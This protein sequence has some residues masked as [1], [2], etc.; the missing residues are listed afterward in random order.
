M[1]FPGPTNMDKKTKLLQTILAGAGAY[2]AIGAV[3][4]FLGLTIFPFYVNNLY[5]PYHDTLVAVAAAIFSAS[6]FVAAKNP[7]RHGTLINLFLFGATLG[8]AGSLWLLYSVDFAALGAPEKQI[9]TIVE[10]G[11]L[12]IFVA[13][14]CVLKPRKTID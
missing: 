12:L 8:I 9:Q 5:N 2:Y 13:C 10:T 1:K 14:L 11:L 6:F 7:A 3:A 4:H